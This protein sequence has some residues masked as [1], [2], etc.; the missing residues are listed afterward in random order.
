MLSRR[1]VIAAR[2]EAVEGTAEAI[3]VADS[4]IL[5]IDC[6]FTADVKM[7]DRSNVQLN[8]LS[9]LVPIPGAQSGKIAFKVELKG[10]GIAYSSSVKPAVGKF[11]QA[12]GFGETIVT[13][14]G[15]ETAT[16]L[17]ASTG[18][19]SLTIWLYE[20]GAVRKLRG[21]RGT[22][23]FSG[24]LGEPVFAEFEFTGIY[25]GAPTLA[26]ITPTFET[27]VPPVLMNATMTIDSY[28]GIAET[29]SIDMGNKIDLRSSM[30]AANGYISTAINDRNV[31]GKLDPEMVL[32]ATYDFYTKW[33]SGNAGALNIGPISNGNYNKFAI[34]APKCVYKAVA[35]GDRNG[36]ITADLDMALCMN[37]GDDEIQIQFSK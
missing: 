3:T 19:P 37:T 13:T 14:A 16:Y 35:E 1:R 4:G 7:Y 20:D 11:L 2:I 30:N 29:F 31:T 33:T 34:T 21:A 18:V 8:T 27:Q 32:A 9:N 24:K 6:K 5:A 22:V 25:D 26:M 12:A 36:V 23:K 17:P 10:T 28:A 15:S